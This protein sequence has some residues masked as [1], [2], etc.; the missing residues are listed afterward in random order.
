MKR[1]YLPPQFIER[2]KKIFEDWDEFLETIKTPLPVCVRINSIKKGEDAIEMLEQFEP[3]PLKWYSKGYRL[4][5]PDGIGNS[6][7]F[8]LG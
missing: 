3:H 7:P 1:F 5:K 8:F 6:L 4:G 2:Y